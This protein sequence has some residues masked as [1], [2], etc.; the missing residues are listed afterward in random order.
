[1]IK[2]IVNPWLID[3]ECNY[4]SAA[5]NICGTNPEEQGGCVSIQMFHNLPIKR[6][7]EKGVR[8]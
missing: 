3:E 2:R 8:F 7:P 6:S 5:L 4:A 1:M